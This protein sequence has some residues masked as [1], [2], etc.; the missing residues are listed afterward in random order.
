LSFYKTSEKAVK[1]LG[2]FLFP[3]SINGVDHI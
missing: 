1:P 3:A 2:C